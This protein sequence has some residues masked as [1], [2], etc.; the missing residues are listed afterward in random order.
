VVFLIEAIFK[1]IGLGKMYFKEGWNCLDFFILA[2]RLISLIVTRA[3]YN[4]EDNLA[5]LRV[6]RLL[7]LIK[8]SQRLQSIFNTIVSSLPG[9][10]NTGTLLFLIMYVYAIIGIQIFS[11]AA[12]NDWGTNDLFNYS[13]FPLAFLS[14]VAVGTGD[15]GPGIMLGTTRSYSIEW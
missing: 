8:R 1:I 12:W 10:G 9:I 6:F 15:S 7:R 5:I 14:L 2:V 4:I 3:G 13:S 11:T